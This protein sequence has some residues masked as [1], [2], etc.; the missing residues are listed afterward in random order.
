MYALDKGNKFLLLEENY[1]T[2]TKNRWR[3]ILNCLPILFY[4][5]SSSS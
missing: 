5:S 4:P 3:I 1:G 2:M